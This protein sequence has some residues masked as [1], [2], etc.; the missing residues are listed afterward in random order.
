M[1]DEYHF[2][3]PVLDKVAKKWYYK[4]R[5]R[6]DYDELKNNCVVAYSEIYHLK[7]ERKW[8]RG[9]FCKYLW[10]SCYNCIVSVLRKQKFTI[11][12]DDVQLSGSRK[13]FEELFN[14][15]WFGYVEK[16]LSDDAKEVLRIVLDQ[17][18]KLEEAHRL[19]RPTKIKISKICK[20][21][22]IWV[23]RGLRKWSYPRIDN[24]ISQVRLALD[25][26]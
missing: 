15:Y 2:V 20:E 10:M 19:R 18:E 3:E 13:E 14:K 1:W 8:S 6:I 21:D 17:P 7:E 25:L 9:D 11:S 4:L 23:M 26:R 22:L 5:G 16:V 24:A 12:I